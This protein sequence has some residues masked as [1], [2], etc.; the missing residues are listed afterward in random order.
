MAI[1]FSRLKSI[2][3]N[4]TDLRLDCEEEWIVFHISH[5]ESRKLV[6]LERASEELPQ[7]ERE[8]SQQ[9][10]HLLLEEILTRHCGETNLPDWLR[11][12][13]R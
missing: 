9:K 8:G 10:V 6:E 12:I 3:V 5:N 13:E 4:K 1:D 11:R 2:Y 7:E